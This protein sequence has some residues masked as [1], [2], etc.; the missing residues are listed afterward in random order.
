[1]E[2]P[3]FCHVITGFVRTPC[4]LW[5]GGAALYLLVQLCLLCHPA[6]I[7]VPSLCEVLAE[8]LP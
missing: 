7:G 5:C 2:I 8:Q 3:V 6:V 1:M 4:C